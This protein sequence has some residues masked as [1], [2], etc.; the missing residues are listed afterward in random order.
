LFDFVL[1]VLALFDWGSDALLLSLRDDVG[2]F[3]RSGE[4]D[5]AGVQVLGHDWNF[6]LQTY[7]FSALPHT[8]FVLF[9]QSLPWP[10]G[11]DLL[12]HCVLHFVYCQLLFVLRIFKRQR[13]YCF[14]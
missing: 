6:A 14:V 8:Q 2:F 12:F 3:E 11:C 1:H 5:V 9:K 7:L 10:G 13:F 4:R